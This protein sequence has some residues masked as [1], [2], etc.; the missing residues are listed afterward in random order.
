MAN[1]ARIAFYSILLGFAPCL[2]AQR[3]AAL[4]RDTSYVTCGSKPALSRTVTS[5]V[6]VSPD[7]KRRAYT[8]GTARLVRAGANPE[9]AS[10]MCVNNSS[11]FVSS[12][13][14]S[15]ELV[16]L[17]EANDSETG[18][19]LR[20]VDWSGD[21][22]R[23]LLELAQW[24]YDSPGATR[25]PL[26]YQA[27][28]GV[29]EQPDLS[30]SFHKQ[31]GLNCSLDVHVAGFSNE[32]KIIVETEP[33]TPEEEEVL[34]TPSCARKKSQW[35]VNSRTESIVQTPE[36]AKLIHNAKIVPRSEK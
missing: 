25:T 27:E 15:F 2:A 35:T 12:K 33:L 14:D 36:T 6:F 24:Q 8:R 13:G 18:N 7:G 16:F 21:S 1:M 26:I 9:R 34:A 19:S 3:D 20:I 32:D 29:F 4:T 22:R 31:Y 5:D 23:L 17:E 30:R 10:A 28:A 11:L